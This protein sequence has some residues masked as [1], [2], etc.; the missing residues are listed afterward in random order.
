VRQRSS[1]RRRVTAI[2]GVALVLC[3]GAAGAAGP[4]ANS[5]VSFATVAQGQS[6][7]GGVE[8]PGEWV[9]GPKEGAYVLRTPK[10]IAPFVDAS[11][12]VSL[13]D[14]AAIR[15]V[16]FRRYVIVA[17]WAGVWNSCNSVEIVKLLRKRK[18]LV[19][20]LVTSP[21]ARACLTQ[22]TGTSYH[23]VKVRRAAFRAAPPRRFVL[24]RLNSPGG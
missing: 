14:E 3:G 13:P 1:P 5:A 15:R 12:R 2:F 19:V 22:R 10:D 6:I 16:D 23:F 9:P 4:L 8:N 11:I 7:D 24:K 17:A 20:S 21:G 18:T